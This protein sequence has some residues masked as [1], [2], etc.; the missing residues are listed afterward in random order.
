MP[1]MKM[2][3]PYTKKKAS[4]TVS[5]P[6]QAARNKGMSSPIALP[7]ELR[8]VTAKVSFINGVDKNEIRLLGVL[9]R[10]MSLIIY[11]AMFFYT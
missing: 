10:P 5:D 9:C 3:N 4:V 8:T 1:E 11:K 6:N 2:T 7:N